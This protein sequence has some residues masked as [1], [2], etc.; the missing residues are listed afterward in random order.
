MA[1]AVARRQEAEVTSL[2]RRKELFA[3]ERSVKAQEEHGKQA[4]QSANKDIPNE[5]VEAAGMPRNIS[6]AGNGCGDEIASRIQGEGDM[7]IERDVR[8][9]QSG[10]LNEERRSK[11]YNHMMNRCAP[12]ASSHEPGPLP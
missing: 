2:S 3:E 6:A 8:E 4:S 1:H 10:G 12:V 9:V 11:K 7:H 5:E